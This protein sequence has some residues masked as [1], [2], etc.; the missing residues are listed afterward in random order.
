MLGETENQFSL[1][2]A[3][4][5]TRGTQK[6]K[7]LSVFIN[8]HILRFSGMVFGAMLALLLSGCATASHRMDQTMDSWVGCNYR[9]LIASWGPPTTT[10]DDG[11]GGQILIYQEGRA[12]ETTSYAPS[13][14]TSFRAPNSPLPHQTMTLS[15]SGSSSSESSNYA[16]TRSFY[17]NQKGIIYAWR[18]NGL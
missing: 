11:K 6:N 15:T 16:V 1:T 9:D 18:W 17:V 5:R 4:F 12:S 3:V 2:R 10:I 7:F 14:S 8:M 13:Y